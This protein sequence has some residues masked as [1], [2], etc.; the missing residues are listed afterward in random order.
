MEHILELPLQIS[1][2]MPDSRRSIRE[3]LALKVGSVLAL[4][5]DADTPVLLFANGKTV[6][7]GDIVVAGKNF[8]VQVTS[9]ELHGNRST[10]A[11]PS[12]LPSQS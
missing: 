6:A 2:R 4:D 9:V 12:I 10:S 3:V 7:R 11:S 8:G 5:G 1:A